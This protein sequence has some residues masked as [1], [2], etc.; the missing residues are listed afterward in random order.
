MKILIFYNPTSCFKNN[1]E[2]VFIDL[3]ADPVNEEQIKKESTNIK[4][5]I[6]SG[7]DG[8]ISG[9][10]KLVISLQKGTNFLINIKGIIFFYLLVV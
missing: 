6:I 7:G 8:T 4:A 1:Y 3:T 10:T 9:F 5:I 2:I